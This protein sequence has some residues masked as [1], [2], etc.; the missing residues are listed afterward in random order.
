MIILGILYQSEDHLLYHP[1]LPTHARV[2]VPIPTMFGLP[3]ENLYIR[4]ADGTLLHM[5][6]IKQPL[7]ERSTKCPTIVFF[8]GNAGNIGHRLSNASGLFHTLKCNLLLLEY[9]GYGLSEGVPSEEGLYM[10][11]RSA[12]DY[13]TTR[14]D[15]NK[16]EIVIFGRSLGR[17]LF[18]NRTSDVKLNEN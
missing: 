7:T 18:P 10:D 12:V 14:S 15:I 13:I 4:S 5:F 2:F 16:S 11:A 3:Y 1:E 6:F 9:R 8:H 17:I